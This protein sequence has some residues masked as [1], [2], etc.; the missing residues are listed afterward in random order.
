MDVCGLAH[1][2]APVGGRERELDLAA[3]REEGGG[4]HD[5]LAYE[6]LAPI[7]PRDPDLELVERLELDRCEAGREHLHELLA[8]LH[9]RSHRADDV[10]ARSQREAA[11]DRDEPV[12]RPETDDPA[13]G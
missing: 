10:V 9:R 1:E 4:L 13:P 8:A 2:V 11:F 3:A 6:W 12:R 7:E 5:P